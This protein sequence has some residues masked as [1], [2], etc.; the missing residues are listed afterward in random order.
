[1]KF[2]SMELGIHKLPTITEDLFDLD[3]N[4]ALWNFLLQNPIVIWNWHSYIMFEGSQQKKKV[5]RSERQQLP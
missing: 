5:D 1:M 3:T 4:W 2:Q